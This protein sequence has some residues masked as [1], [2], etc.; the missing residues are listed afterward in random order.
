VFSPRERRQEEYL[1]GVPHWQQEP[2]VLREPVPFIALLKSVDAVVSAGGTMMREAA[3][4]GVPAYSIFRGSIGAVDRYLA[5]IERLSLL[6][7]PSDFPRLRLIPHRAI[8]PLRTG[9]S[10]AHDVSEMIL[11]RADSAS[12]L[13]QDTARG[14]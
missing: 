7:S 13:P 6:S 14:A 8:S 9:S 10:A 2:I 12:R 3:Y 11:N 5:S 1:D 4:L